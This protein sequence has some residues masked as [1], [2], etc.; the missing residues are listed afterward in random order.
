MYVPIIPCF[1]NR[2]CPGASYLCFLTILMVV[3]I[4]LHPLLGP[5]FDLSW[6]P[7]MVCA[8]GAFVYIVHLSLGDSL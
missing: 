5:Y 7:N 3:G 6:E 8:Q 2:Q 1:P 4:T